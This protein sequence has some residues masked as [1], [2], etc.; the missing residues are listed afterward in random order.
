MREKLLIPKTIEE[1]KE[2]LNK[3]DERTK[4]ISGGTDMILKLKKNGFEE[5]TLID[6]SGVSE[7]KYI[8]EKDGKVFIGAGTTL[9]EISENSI[10]KKYA[11]L[12]EK[13]A[14]SVGSTQIRNAATIGGNIA[15]S[16]AGADLIPPLIAMEA[17]LLLLGKYGNE[18]IVKIEDF[19]LGNRKNILET[20]EMVFEVIF[21]KPYDLQYFGKIGSRSRVTISK[22]NMA[23]NILIENDNIKDSKIVFGALGST[24]FKSLKIAEFMNG[25]NLTDLDLCEFKKIFTLQVDEA[26]PNRASRIYKREAVTSLAEELYGI[27]KMEVEV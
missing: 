17:E 15:N 11:K 13:A 5:I 24:A 14:D 10:I 3:S 22:L 12:L 6:L 27:L 8:E 19:L 4:F 18:R 1:L 16:F 23:A 21:N 26:I 25:K 20:G 7:L 2:N 9:S